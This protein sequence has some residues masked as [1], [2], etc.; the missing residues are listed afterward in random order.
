MVRRRA[1]CNIRTVE[2]EDESGFLLGP[3]N[4]RTL[5]VRSPFS[6]TGIWRGPVDVWR[7]VHSSSTHDERGEGKHV[8]GYTFEGDSLLRFPYPSCCLRGNP[9]PLKHRTLE[10]RTLDSGFR[11]NH[12]R[13]S[14]PY[15]R[16][17]SYVYKSRKRG[18]LS[19]D[20]LTV[21]GTS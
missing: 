17:L 6:P 15:S 11:N 13:N 1:V 21:P 9:K 2:T 12:L 18:H 20:L 7:R 8:G 16:G 3:P 14:I 10:S 19:N 5:R 4:S